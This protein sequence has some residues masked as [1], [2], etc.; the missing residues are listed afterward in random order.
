MKN[1]WRV[2][3]SSKR[4]EKH[5]LRVTSLWL[6]SG[7]GMRGYSLIRGSGSASVV[8]DSFPPFVLS[9]DFFWI[10]LR[11]ACPKAW[12]SPGV[13]EGVWGRRVKSHRAHAPWL[14]TLEIMWRS[15]NR[16]L[17]LASFSCCL[18]VLYCLWASE[19]CP[20]SVVQ[21]LSILLQ[22]SVSI[23]DI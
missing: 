14:Q 15:Y 20:S 1:I 2:G 6:R 12:Y 21:S 10:W 17:V 18:P 4:F 7:Q 11:K 16:C 13:I 23:Y 8:F 19:V 9:F 22:H 3:I 5:L